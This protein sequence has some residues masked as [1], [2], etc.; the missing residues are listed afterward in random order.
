MNP[1]V[2]PL[3]WPILALGAPVLLPWLARKGAA[4]RVEQRAAASRNDGRVLAARALDLPELEFV[5]VAPLVEQA[6]ADGFLA[7]PGVSYWIRTDRGSVL[8]DIGF[9]ACRP[10]V[11]HNA[12]RLGFTLSKVDAV[13][14]SHC[15]PDHMG[16]IAAVRER[17][18]GVPQAIA[19]ADPP[20]HAPVHCRL[21]A[22]EASV[23]DRPRLVAAG[24]AT[25]GPLSRALFI[26]GKVEEQ[27]LVARVR[28]KGT[29][30]ITGCG[31]PGL[32]T[33]LEMA[34]R[35]APGPIHALVGGLHYPVT[36]SRWQASGIALQRIF[37]T[38]KPPWSPISDADL[39]RAI[40]LLN[41]A[42]PDRLL[43][44]AHDTCDHALARFQAELPA[45]VEVLAAGR[46]LRI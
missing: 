20:C 36:A 12:A 15:H 38:G 24:L 25:T 41:G 19:D 4:F 27:A 2:S 46:T 3:W 22:K 14:L 29:V 28:G 1:P 8:F 5:D 11:V 23:P 26:E 44:S 10:A 30:V 33:L 45:R 18:I 35:I 31:H 37:G 7:D 43:V 13:V 32:E 6:H 16:G 40:E 39:G 42:A 9:G 17:R 21:G 34:R